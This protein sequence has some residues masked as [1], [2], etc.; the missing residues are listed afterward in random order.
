MPMSALAAKLAT[1]QP[2]VIS[3]LFDAPKDLVWAVHTDCGHLKHW[4]GP[5]GFPVF[6]CTINPR[7][8]GTFHYGLR[9]AGGEEIWGKFIYHEVTPLERLV[10][11]MSFSD[12]QGGLTRHPYNP[13]WP[14]EILSTVTFAGQ[15]GKTLL[16]ARWEPNTPT[17]KEREAFNAGHESMTMGWTG[18]LD[19][20][21]EYLATLSNR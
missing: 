9:S 8:G 1:D 17:A 15:N 21:T 7:Q 18:T 16:T 5:K 20:L 6:A 2:F 3:R 13:D 19:Q 14:R 11:I 4:W 10:S 12:A